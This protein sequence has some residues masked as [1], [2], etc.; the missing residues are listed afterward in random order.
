MTITATNKRTKTHPGT[1]VNLTIQL[2]DL[3]ETVNLQ[4]CKAVALAEEMLVVVL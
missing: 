4:K 1:V 3:N 2:T